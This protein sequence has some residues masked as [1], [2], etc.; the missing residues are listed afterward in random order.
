[1][2]IK[3]CEFINGTCTHCKAPEQGECEGWVP[4]DREQ[5]MDEIA[6]LTIANK[7]LQDW[8]DAI[9]AD[10]EALKDAAK[11]A[12]VALNGVVDFDPDARAQWSVSGG[13]I[14]AHECNAAI[15]ALK[16]VL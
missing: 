11:L 6:S 15:T 12:L 1:M 7:D 3:P 10:H 16:A 8:F 14:E 4:S 5:F 2:T 13:S 9:K